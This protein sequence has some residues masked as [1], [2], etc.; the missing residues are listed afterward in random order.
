MKTNTNFY[1]GFA[2]AVPRAFADPLAACRFEL[3]DVLYDSRES[4]KGLPQSGHAVQ[5]LEPSRGIGS[6]SSGQ[7]AS[8]FADAWRQE[9]VFEWHDFAAQTKR[10]ITSTQGRLYTL[11]WKGDEA[12]LDFSTPE[13]PIPLNAAT[14]KKHL[15]LI[16]RS[17]THNDGLTFI[18]ATD[19]AADQLKE[20]LHK[21][22]TALQGPLLCSRVLHP[23][24]SLNLDAEFLPTVHAAVF[25]L[26]DVA[27]GTIEQALQ[28]VLYKPSSEKAAAAPRFRLASHGILLGTKKD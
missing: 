19:V 7:D 22:T 28:A 3:G 9:V 4:Y 23:A 26:G 5:V 21:V 25:H 18:M 27:P 6:P 15:E 11:L 8:V 12:T 17:L 20:K 2:W 1:D 14:F 13:P 24:N 16:A 10:T